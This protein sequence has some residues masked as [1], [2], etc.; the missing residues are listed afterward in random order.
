VILKKTVPLFVTAK[1]HVAMRTLKKR[2]GFKVRPFG[3]PPNGLAP[4]SPN[5]GMWTPTPQN[6]ISSLTL[7]REFLRLLL[8]RPSS[9]IV[10]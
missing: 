9:G 4:P 8:L 7:K 6:L 2:P 1:E 5:I 10:D 3:G